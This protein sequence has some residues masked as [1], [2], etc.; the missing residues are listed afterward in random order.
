MFGSSSRRSKAIFGNEKSFSR[1]P[2]PSSHASDSN[3][4]PPPG[5]DSLHHVLR[6]SLKKHFDSDQSDTYNLT[7]YLHFEF[8]TETCPGD[9]NLPERRSCKCSFVYLNCNYPLCVFS[10]FVHDRSL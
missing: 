8:E 10:H 6:Q 7:K 9:P 1:S 5:S 3:S 2:S 4:N